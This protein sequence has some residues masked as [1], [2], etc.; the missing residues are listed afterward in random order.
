MGDG[1]VA[2]ILDVGN[3]A[4]IAGLTSVE[5]TDR[6]A[7][8]AMEDDEANRGRNDKQSILLFRAADEE[9]FAL[10]INHVERIEKI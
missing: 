1:R 9:Q 5:G 6:A 3:L 2:L 10:P 8:V 7:E 4:H